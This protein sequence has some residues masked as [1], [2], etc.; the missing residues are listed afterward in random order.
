MPDFIPGRLA[1]AAQLELVLFI[2]FLGT[3][4]VLVGATVRAR[5]GTQRTAAIA[6]LVVLVLVVGTIIAAVVWYFSHWNLTF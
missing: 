6:A 3:V 2:A 4:A 1:P 5:T